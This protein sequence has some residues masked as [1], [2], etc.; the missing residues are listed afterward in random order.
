MALLPLHFLYLKLIIPV[1]SDLPSLGIDVQLHSIK[2]VHWDHHHLVDPTLYNVHVW[3]F[4]SIPVPLSCRARCHCGDLTVM[5]LWWCH[6]DNAT[7]HVCFSLTAVF[8]VVF[9]MSGGCLEWEWR[10]DW[11]QVR[12]NIRIEQRV[13]PYIGDHQLS[14]ILYT[15]GMS[16][17][18]TLGVWVLL[19][20][21]ANPLHGWRVVSLSLLLLAWERTTTLLPPVFANYHLV[22]ILV[23]VEYAF[24]NLVRFAVIIVPPLPRVCSTLHIPNIGRW[25][26][27]TWKSLI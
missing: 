15:R 4:L 19:L 27:E 7:G 8:A 9:L 14:A 1:H 11:E 22:C 16:R 20:T 3:D 26:L 6:S 25:V 5:S 24:Q 10:L 13:L 2:L 12:R 18:C 21:A 23:F 17:Y